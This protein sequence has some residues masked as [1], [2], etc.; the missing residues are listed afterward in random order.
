MRGLL[1]DGQPS[2]VPVRSAFLRLGDEVW[3]LSITAV[4]PLAGRPEGL[5]IA[6]LPLQIHGVRISE[7][8]LH[9]LGGSL[10][11]DGLRLSDWRVAGSAAIPLRNHLRE[12][13]GFVVWEPPRPGAQSCSKSPSPSASRC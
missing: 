6:E 11:V 7:D 10:L 2:Q 4:T 9:E 1:T 3:A 5:S 12:S 13:I 8:R